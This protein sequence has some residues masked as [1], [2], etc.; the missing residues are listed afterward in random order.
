MKN[1]FIF[2][3]LRL[4][5]C[6]A[7]LVLATAGCKTYQ[8]VRPQFD[9]AISNFKS[10]SEIENRAVAKDEERQLRIINGAFEQLESLVVESL[11]VSLR[12]GWNNTDFKDSSS[13]CGWFGEPDF[14]KIAPD[15]LSNQRSALAVY[16]GHRFEIDATTSPTAFQVF[17]TWNGDFTRSGVSIPDDKL[18]QLRRD[19]ASWLK[20]FDETVLRGA[21]VVGRVR[22]AKD[23]AASSSKNET[24][25]RKERLD[26]LYG[27]LLD[28]TES[29]RDQAGAL[30][31]NAAVIG[32]AS[33][34]AEFANKLVAKGIS[35]LEKP[36]ASNKERT[37]HGYRN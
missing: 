7:P 10:A 32:F 29:A 20:N 2:Q 22:E 33:K 13:W 37:N 12:S 15:A 34:V 16:L 11:R 31:D 6:V 5:C 8:D 9:S 21:P 36:D 27:N 30:T 1:G 18:K 26:L 19:Y 17:A 35:G 25:R 28:V 4:L 14:D 24:Q 3:E 23:A